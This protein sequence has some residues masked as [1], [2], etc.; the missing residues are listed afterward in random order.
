LY[1]AVKA[2]L[3][4]TD[5]A[6][7]T[8]EVNAIL[9]GFN[10][11]AA[12]V[13]YVGHGSVN[14]WAGETI[15]STASIA[16]LTNGNNLPIVLSM[17]CVDGVWYNP[18][19]ASVSGLAE[20]LVRAPAKGAVASFSPSGWGTT[21][22]H[23]VLERGFLTALFNQHVLNLGALTTAAKLS[24]YGHADIDLIHQFTLLGDPALKVKLTLPKLY[25]FIPSVSR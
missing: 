12:L 13:N 20:E 19:P 14:R 11:G 5:A 2:Y 16:G 4:G 8:Q 6:S 21:Y 3:A 22:S 24:V 1:Q 23:D 15:F 7:V 10:S 9:A 25:Q 17:T 18:V